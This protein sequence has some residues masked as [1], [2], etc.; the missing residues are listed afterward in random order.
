MSVNVCVVC[1]CLP[2]SPSQL[3]WIPSGGKRK[4]Q[5]AWVHCAKGLQS[6][7]R[8]IPGPFLD[9][10]RPPVPPLAVRHT[11]AQPTFLLYSSGTTAST[12][13]S[14]PSLRSRAMG[15]RISERQFHTWACSSPLLRMFLKKR[16]RRVWRPGLT[17]PAPLVH[18][19]FT[20]RAALVPR[21]FGVSMDMR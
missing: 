20:T 12:T 14:I 7:T 19:A 18:H 9:P 2:L 5:H 13:H 1:E 6:A 21:C 8:V 10:L 11:S 17:T 16:H 4:P 15:G 3:L